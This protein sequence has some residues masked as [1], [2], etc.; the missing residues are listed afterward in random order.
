MTDL[1]GRD[2]IPGYELLIK[3]L[4]SLLIGACVEL[5][6]A[7]N[8]S[9]RCNIEQRREMGHH[10]ATGIKILGANDKETVFS[11]LSIQKT[12]P[13]APLHTPL[14]VRQQ[15][16]MMSQQNCSADLDSSSFLYDTKSQLS[17]TFHRR[18]VL[19]L[20]LESFLCE[21][22]T[23]SSS[24]EDQSQMSSEK[25]D[26]LDSET[27]REIVCELE[28]EWESSQ[29]TLALH[30]RELLTEDNLAF[31]EEVVNELDESFD[32]SMETSTARDLAKDT[33]ISVP[34]STNASLSGV[35]INVR[36][37]STTDTP[38]TNFSSVELNVSRSSPSCGTPELFSSQKKLGR[39]GSASLMREM[40]SSSF[41]PE[42][43]GATPLVRDYPSSISSTPTSLSSRTHGLSKRS[44]LQDSTITP[45]GHCFSHSVVTSQ[46]LDGSSVSCS[47][48]GH[49]DLCTPHSQG[50]YSRDLFTSSVS[51]PDL[52]S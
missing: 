8:C 9:S 43:F 15:G 11:L 36:P 32:N 37:T 49:T 19:P 3:A 29:Q 7:K 14:P 12:S 10:V 34:A 24:I 23:G 52:F 2:E 16:R 41:T 22:Q 39:H 21:T 6:F 4:R 25:D 42:L 44:L 46:L 50:E 38:L 5:N 18:T 27:S 1:E 26:S 45:L 20:K 17:G 48:Q 51:S 35:D 13:L 40:E 30:T 28:S 47:R 31:S 33:S